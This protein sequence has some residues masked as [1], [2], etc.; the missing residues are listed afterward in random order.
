M[1][2]GSISRPDTER[3]E[4]EGNSIFRWHHT[5]ARRLQLTQGLQ[6]LYAA[7]GDPYASLLRGFDDDLRPVHELLRQRGSLWTSRLE[8]WV[9]A[10]Y[11][12]A[13]ELLGHPA[14][15][16][17]RGEQPATPTTATW[18]ADFAGIST[19]QVEELGH[20]LPGVDALRHRYELV[21][22]QVGPEFDVVADVAE[23]VPAAVLGE[24]FAVDGQPRRATLTA[25]CADAVVAVAVA[26]AVAVDS[27]LCPQKLET[28]YRM[29]EAVDELRTL[30]DAQPLGILHAT[31]GVRLSADLV[32]KAVL[33]L[34]DEGRWAE[35][36]AD[37]DQVPAAVEETLR[38]D[39]PVQIHTG[40]AQ[41]DLQV[42]SQQVLKGSHVAVII[43]AANR[44]PAVFSDADRFDPNRPGG[45]SLA[46]L[47]PGGPAGLV[48]PLARAHAES[49]LR[50]LVN[51]FPGLRRSGPALRRRRAPVTR[52]LLR[53]PVSTT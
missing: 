51:R 32:A 43:A 9:S 24:L 47:I 52:G 48:L 25:R 4:R 44:D 42:D 49:A 13:A 26:V 14:L 3:A 46:T 15:A 30:L 28:T 31:F 29:I 39:P 22:D 16:T 1:T 37:P 19:A 45:Q 53:L 40:T 18:D 10:R 41:I 17:H 12:T 36:V 27:L 23:K 33:A 5:L 21:L 50:A 11:S 35:L 7:N 8:T 34:L 2:A 6:W 20:R 38:Y